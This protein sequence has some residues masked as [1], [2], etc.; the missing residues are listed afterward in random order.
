MIY[1]SVGWL[2]SAPDTLLLLNVFALVNNCPVIPSALTERC[3]SGWA[4][5]LATAPPKRF[6]NCKF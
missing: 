4:I 5:R 6:I 3:K 2:F 1:I